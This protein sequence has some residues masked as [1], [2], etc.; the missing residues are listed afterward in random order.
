MRLILCLLLIAL[1]SARPLF[2]PYMGIGHLKNTEH[3]PK[4]KNSVMHTVD[5]KYLKLDYESELHDG[6]MNL[7]KAMDVEAVECKDEFITVVLSSYNK[8]LWDSVRVIAG[9]RE[10]G[11]KDKKEKGKEGKE[12]ILRKVLSVTFVDAQTLVLHTEEATYAH[13][14]KTLNVD[15]STNLFNSKDAVPSAT[16]PQKN[17]K[18]R[19]WFDNFFTS[20]WNEVTTIAGDVTSAV[21]SAWKTVEDLAEGDYSGSF[22]P[23]AHFGFANTTS[24]HNTAITCSNCSLTAQLSVNFQISLENYTLN[25][26]LLALQGSAN[27]FIEGQLTATETTWSDSGSVSI[28]TFPVATIPLDIGIPI[29]LSI[30]VPVTAGFAASVDVAATMSAHVALSGTFE[31]GIEFDNAT[32]E[33]EYVNSHSWTHSGNFDSVDS[34]SVDADVSV[35]IMPTFV[36]EVDKLGGPYVALKP[37]AEI[38][39]GATANDTQSPCS[40]NT[41]HAAFNWGLLISLGANIDFY[42]IQKTY[43]PSTLYSM[44][45]PI[46]SGCVSLSSSGPSFTSGLPAP[47]DVWYADSVTPSCGNFTTLQMATQIVEVSGNTTYSMFTYYGLVNGDM[48]CTAQALYALE[49]AGT[50][51]FSAVPQTNGNG[52]AIGYAWCDQGAPTTFVVHAASGKYSD[53]FDTISLVTDDNCISTQMTRT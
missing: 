19:G 2:S 8:D 51:A 49:M 3:S 23:S 52:Y 13:A 46:E 28:G 34:A 7:D 40:N 18:E 20:A 9:G 27:A 10:W 5:G 47:S 50:N 35:Y 44:K 25:S 14:F 6:V 11:C 1:C 21:E 17:M 29:V 30:T 15:F 36:V 33:F 4:S 24:F 37:Y 38:S 45:L 42:V 16:K 41:F 53:N 39:A 32:G 26:M 31:F 12:A 43:G 22:D 48:Y